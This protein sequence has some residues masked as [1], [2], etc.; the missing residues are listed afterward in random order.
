MEVIQ[1]SDYI[2]Y[3]AM[4]EN[5]I[6]GL[7]KPLK[8]ITAKCEQ[9]AAKYIKI[10]TSFLESGTY[11]EIGESSKKLKDVESQLIRLLAAQ[12]R[13]EKIVLR[14]QQRLDLFKERLDLMGIYNFQVD[15]KELEEFKAIE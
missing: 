2:L 8:N 6:G 15:K 14:N 9:L 3:K 1:D 7:L 13:I 10:K 5:V 11:D 4:A 12:D